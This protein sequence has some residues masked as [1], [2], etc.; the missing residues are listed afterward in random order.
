MFSTP[1]GGALNYR[2][3]VMVFV[4]IPQTI[5][6]YPAQLTASTIQAAPLPPSCTLL[7]ITLG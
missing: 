4:C 6:Q 3:N 7:I 2:R 1:L 5:K